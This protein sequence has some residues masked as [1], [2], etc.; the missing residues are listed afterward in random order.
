MNVFHWKNCTQTDIARILLHTVF[1]LVWFFFTL[2]CKPQNQGGINQWGIPIPHGRDVER[3][4]DTQKT[5]TKNEN[6]KL[7]NENEKNSTRFSKKDQ[8][9]KKPK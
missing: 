7:E 2:Y 8:Q 5:K 3:E 4:R 6:G 9:K 1:G